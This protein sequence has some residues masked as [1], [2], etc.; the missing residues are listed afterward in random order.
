MTDS[1]IRMRHSKDPRYP[2]YRRLRVPGVLMLWLHQDSRG[3]DFCMD[4][5]EIFDDDT[6][7]EHP[8]TSDEAPKPNV[9]PPDGDDEDGC[10]ICRYWC[11]ESEC[12]A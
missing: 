2:V 9:G 11:V 3:I 6:N 4:Y 10:P 12:F 8:G 1:Y 7:E 5:D